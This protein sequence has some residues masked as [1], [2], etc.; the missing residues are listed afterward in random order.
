[1]YLRGESKPNQKIKKRNVVNVWDFFET[2][3]KAVDSGIPLICDQSTWSGRNGYENGTHRKR[4][5]G[6][7]DERAELWLE[8]FPVGSTARQRIGPAPTHID[9]LGAVVEFIEMTRKFADDI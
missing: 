5:E 6:G 4:T 8:G 3:A 2:A 7:G 9:D 1:L